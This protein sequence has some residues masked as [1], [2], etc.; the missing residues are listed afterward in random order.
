MLV[1]RYETLVCL[2]LLV[3]ERLELSSLITEDARVVVVVVVSDVSDVSDVSESAVVDEELPP[4]SV[5]QE[6]IVKLIS[7][8]TKNSIIVFIMSL[9]ADKKMRVRKIISL[10]LH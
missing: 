5:P 6:I 2:E 1:L 4:L 7:K 9:L 10:S 8:T 3:E